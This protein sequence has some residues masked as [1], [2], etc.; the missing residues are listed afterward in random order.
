[1][2]FCLLA[3]SKI[4]AYPKRKEFAPIGSKF[5]SFKVGS[6]SENEAKVNVAELSL[7]KVSSFPLN[8]LIRHVKCTY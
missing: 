7:L 6:F 3:P 5:F 4:V 8:R 1:M 2:T